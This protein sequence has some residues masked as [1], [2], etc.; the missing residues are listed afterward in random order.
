MLV[1]T[2]ISNANTEVNLW[3]RYEILHLDMVS[4]LTEK[5]YNK[6]LG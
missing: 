4:G 6:K 5:H 3:N 1:K 2:R